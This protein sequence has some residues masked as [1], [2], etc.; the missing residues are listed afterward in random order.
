MWPLVRKQLHHAKAMR[1]LQPE[2]KKIKKSA[3]GDRQKESQLMMELYKEKEINPFSSIGILIVQIPILIGLY[4][5]IRRIIDDP[6]QIISFSYPFL[7]HLGWMHSLAGN[8]HSFDNSLF[9]LVNLTRTASGPSG[10]YWPAMII[11]VASAIAQYLQSKQLMP[12]GKDSR[13]LRAIMREAGE[14]KT[15]DQSEVNA[16]V[17]RSTVIFIPVI[18]FIVSLHL[19]VALPLYWLVSSTMA[20]LQQA[21]VLERDVAEEEIIATEAV[22]KQKRLSLP[23]SPPTPAGVKVTRTNLKE[24]QTGKSSAKRSSK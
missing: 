19:A 17:S 3:A 6:H 15:A 10:V 1:E 20:Y 2:L 11:V 22:K 4:A 16:A 24:Y 21:R 5:S 14:G 7:H 13:S 8:I 23:K 18:V 9:G 12:S